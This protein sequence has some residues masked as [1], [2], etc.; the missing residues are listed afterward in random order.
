[1]NEKL[2]EILNR[3]MNSVITSQQITN[4]GFHRR[5]L[6]ELVDENILKKISRGIYV[7]SDSWEDEFYLLQCKYERGVYSYDT[8]LYLHGY[9]SRV[10]LKYAM[11]FPKGYNASSIK[12]ENIL[13]KR[14]VIE[15]Y[16]L[17]ITEISS[18]Y[19]NKIRVYDLERT[20]CDILRGK[21]SDIQLINEAVC[22]LHRKE[23]FPT[24]ALC[25]QTSC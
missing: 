25:F 10:P 21:G 17:C 15:N 19:G 9:S 16:D 13:V 24:D 23:S 14:V 18:P 5:V 12:K 20:L 4:A 8:A 7:L 6:S 2:S 1:M 3:S 22:F 11:T